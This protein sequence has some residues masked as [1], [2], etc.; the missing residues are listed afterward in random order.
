MSIPN[1]VFFERKMENRDQSRLQAHPRGGE[2]HYTAQSL[3]IQ[4]GNPTKSAEWY[5]L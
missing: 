2:K 3:R 4:V 5:P 1:I